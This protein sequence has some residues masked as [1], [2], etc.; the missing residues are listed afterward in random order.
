MEARERR[1][2]QN[3][4]LFRHVNENMLKAGKR[5]L[6]ADQTFVCECGD[7]SC[8]DQIDVD[9]DDYERVRSNPIQFVVVPGHEI[10]EYEK[11]VE[12]N[13]AWARTEK[14]G[15]AAPFVARQDP[16]RNK[17]GSVAR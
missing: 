4:A 12:R 8:T 11:V 15:D 10:P 16:R 9:V 14:I 17:G 13:A 7:D 1:V 2:A 5:F 3:E 6:A